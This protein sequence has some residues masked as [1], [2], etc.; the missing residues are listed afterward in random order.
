LMPGSQLVNRLQ[1]LKYRV[2]TINDANL[3]AEWAERAKPMLVLAD[4]ESSP[5]EVCTAISRLKQ[6]P[7]TSHLPIIGFGIQVLPAIQEQARKA[8]VTLIANEAAILGH[9]SQL[10]QQALQIE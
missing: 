8:G 6:N 9:L 10:L 5:T 4:L 3:L 1:D 7:G 2:Q